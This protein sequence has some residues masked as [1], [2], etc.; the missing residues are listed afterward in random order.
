MSSIVHP[1]VTFADE[2][3]IA[4]FCVIGE[5]A[6]GRQ[7]GEVATTIGA[8]AVIRS[9]TVI[10]AGNVIGDGFQTGHGALVRED[11]RIGNDVSIGSHSIVEHH[12]VIGDGVR[13]HSNAFIPEYS[14]LEEGCWIGPNVV[15][16]NAR[17]PR[18]AAV[19]E[20]LVGATV[21]AGAKVGAGV[22]LLPGVVIGRNALVGAGSV[23]VRDVGDG[24]VVAGNPARVIRHIKDIPAYGG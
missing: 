13:I 17:Y 18:S 21:K 10:Y 4:E 20:Q 7:A 16:T 19:K 12:V 11:N 2:P 15:V 22:V 5:P 14:V 6:R 24:E 9:H 23:V 8:R 3:S 1:N